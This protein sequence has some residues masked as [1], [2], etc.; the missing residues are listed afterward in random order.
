MVDEQQKSVIKQSFEKFGS[1]QSRYVDSSEISRRE[2]VFRELKR[3][4]NDYRKKF[5]LTENNYFEK[6]AAKLERQALRFRY[7]G[8]EYVVL[9]CRDCD[10]PYLGASRC[11]SRLCKKCS[12]KHGAR[13]RK[14]QIRIVKGLN[15]GHGYGL[16]FLTLTKKVDPLRPPNEFDIRNVSTCARKLIKKLYPK[17]YGCGAFATIEIGENNNIHMHLLVFGPYIAQRK[18][19]DLWLK[20]TG[21]SPVV[22][23]KGVRSPIKCVNYLLKYISK[24][25]EYRDPQ[26]YAQYIDSITGV[27]RIHTYGVFYNCPLMKKESC[28]CVFCGGKLK[29]TGTDGGMNIP[30]EAVFLCDVVNFATSISE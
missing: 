8:Y 21:D 10:K 29:F 30:L 25:P 15:V 1:A 18:I 6:K 4:A 20:I 9:K 12:R 3:Y 24:P 27:R 19:S 2:K 5:K 16:A 22:F 11:E 13:V 28:P 14:R 23:I 7:C 17:K 26:K